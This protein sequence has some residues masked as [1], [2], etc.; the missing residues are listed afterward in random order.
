MSLR[1]RHAFI[2]GRLADAFGIDENEAQAVVR[3]ATKL[4]EFLA[5]EGTNPASHILVYC[6]PKDTKN[7]V[8][9]QPSC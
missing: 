3:K 5:G 4:H 8:S 9:D 7:E 2:A 6:Q 1:P